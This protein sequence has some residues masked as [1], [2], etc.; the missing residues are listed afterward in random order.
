MIKKINYTVFM[1][2]KTFYEKEMKEN[3]YHWKKWELMSKFDYDFLRVL[4]KELPHI[5]H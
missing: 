4:S 2:I 5:E 3:L 1:D